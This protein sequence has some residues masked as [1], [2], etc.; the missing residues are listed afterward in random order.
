MMTNKRDL[1]RTINYICS[2]LFAEC[3]AASLY[4]GKPDEE[5]VNAVLTSILHTQQDYVRRISHP[6]PGMSEKEFFKNL[7][8]SFNKE[9][10]EIIDHIANLS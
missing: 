9:V 2:E 8:D 10:E 6:Q 7:T 3:V 4:S 5:N 1:K